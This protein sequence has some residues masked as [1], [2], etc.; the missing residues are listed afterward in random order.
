MTPETSVAA[1]PQSPWV[2]DFEQMAVKTVAEKAATDYMAAVEDAV[3]EVQWQ[4][5]D[6]CG[7]LERMLE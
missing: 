5:A 7:L 1:V 6:P 2:T 3:K 4:A